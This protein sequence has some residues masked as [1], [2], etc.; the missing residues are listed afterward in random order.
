M[1]VSLTPEL[2]RFIKSEVEAG[3]F[4]SADDV[5]RAGLKALSER[6]EMNAEIN[7]MIEEGEADIAAGRTFSPEEARA[8]LSEHREQLTRELDQRARAK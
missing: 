6:Q 8:R 5:V 3:R 4:R 1:N 7:T 2:E